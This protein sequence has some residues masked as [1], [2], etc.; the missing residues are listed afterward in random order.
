MQRV[1]GSLLIFYALCAIGALTSEEK[2]TADAVVPE[3]ATVPAQSSGVDATISDLESD[4]DDLD[5][6]VQEEANDGKLRPFLDHYDDAEDRAAMKNVKPYTNSLGRNMITGKKVTKTDNGMADTSH[7]HYIG[8]TKYVKPPGYAW[9]DAYVGPHGHYY[10]GSGRRRIGAGFGRRRAPVPLTKKDVKAGKKIWDKVDPSTKTKVKEGFHKRTV[11]DKASKEL[12]SK[13][14]KPFEKG[15]K[16]Y[17]KEFKGLQDGPTFYE[18]HNYKGPSLTTNASIPDLSMTHIHSKDISS[19]KVPAGWCATLYT[20]PNY[21][22]QAKEFC[23]P[24]EKWSL[25]SEPLQLK[26]MG[27]AGAIKHYTTSWDDE[28]ASIM[29]TKY[30]Y[31]VVPPAKCPTTCGMSAAKHKGKVICKKHVRGLKLVTSKSSCK[32]VKL[33]RPLTPTRKCHHT[34]KCAKSTITTTEVATAKVITKKMARDLVNNLVKCGGKYGA[35]CCNDQETMKCCN[36]LIGGKD[37]KTLSTSN[38]TNNKWSRW[39]EVEGGLMWIVSNDEKCGGKADEHQEGTYDMVFEVRHNASVTISMQGMAESQYENMKILLDGV[40]VAKLEAEDTPGVCKV[41][42]CNMCPVKLPPKAVLLTK[43]K[44]K[45]SI[46]ASTED[47][48]YQNNAYFKVFVSE[49]HAHKPPAACLK[50]QC[51]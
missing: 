32:M 9:E 37:T 44:H 43:G 41:H 2:T 14:K 46:K 4:F 19:L 26:H 27:A 38:T 30:K 22:G 10:L 45:L 15:V 1:A 21:K 39:V 42:T 7:W 17:Y 36:P 23:G 47:M 29:L 8:G 6:L 12:M 18:D 24:L 28:A 5:E 13:S 3:T 40:L 51:K 16:A 33:T 49:F 48:F 35:P 20:E 34:P 25:I 31:E 11:V 50:C